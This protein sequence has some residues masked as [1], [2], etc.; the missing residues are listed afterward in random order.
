MNKLLSLNTGVV[1]Q[2]DLAFG[3]VP[4]YGDVSYAVAVQ[5]D[6][7]R[8]LANLTMAV[9]TFDEAPFSFTCD[10]GKGL[11]RCEA[12]GVYALNS[13]ELEFARMEVLN[14]KP[15]PIVL[16]CRTE[17][18]N[19][20]YIVRGIV[21]FAD[22]LKNDKLHDSNFKTWVKR[23]SGWRGEF[24]HYFLHTQIKRLLK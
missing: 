17:R 12:N 14:G 7:K 21:H 13:T 24:C 19:D 4:K 6:I 22:V 15:Y 20:E 8:Q 23:P 18:A 9:S 5:R 10:C 16:A 11:I 2:D 1:T 3:E